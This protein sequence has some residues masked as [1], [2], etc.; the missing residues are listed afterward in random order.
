M[1]NSHDILE[2]INMIDNENLDIRTM[3]MGISLL[4]CVDSDMTAK[5]ATRFMIKSAAMPGNL[6]KTGEDISKEYGIPIINK[7]ISV[8]PIAMVA[9]ACPGARSG[10]LCQSARPGRTEVGRQFYRRIYRAGAQGFCS[11]RLRPDR[12]HSRRLWR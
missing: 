9:G 1:I 11:R 7:R 2:T 8:T 3:T 4:D 12:Q 6:V 5:P 10:A